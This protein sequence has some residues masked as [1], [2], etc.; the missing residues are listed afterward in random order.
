MTESRVGWRRNEFEG[1]TEDLK[2]LKKLIDKQ[3][4]K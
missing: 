1:L 4:K 3:I 2:T